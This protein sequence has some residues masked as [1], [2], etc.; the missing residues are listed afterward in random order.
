M[1]TYLEVRKLYTLVVVVVWLLCGL[2]TMYGCCCCCC[3]RPD[4]YNRFRLDAR[5]VPLL[6]PRRTILELVERTN[7]FRLNIRSQ[8]VLPPSGKLV[9]LVERANRFSL[10]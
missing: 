6:P 1:F 10:N 9:K 4:R 2:S 5:A 3:S 7:R 8:M